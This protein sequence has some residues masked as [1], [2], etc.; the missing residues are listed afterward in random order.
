MSY[1]VHVTKQT[2]RDLDDAAE[3]IAFALLNPDAASH[4]QTKSFLLL[5]KIHSATVWSMT[6]S[7][8]HGECVL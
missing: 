2:E 1:Y 7:C 5:K 3:C 4:L 6:Q 8:L